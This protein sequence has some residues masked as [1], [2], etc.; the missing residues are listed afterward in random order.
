MAPPD[1]GTLSVPEGLPVLLRDLIHEYTGIFF[2]E[3]R[4]DIML[5]K[6]A[7]LA[8]ARGYRSYM[9]YYYLLKYEDRERV[10]LQKVIE[11]LSVLETYF[12]RE[13]GQI[14]AMVQAVV[15]Q[16]FARNQTPLRI[17]SA[18]CATGE[19]P[20]TIAIAL[21]EAGWGNHP[22]Q[23]MG[24]DASE[25]ALEKARRGVYRERAFR[26]LPLYLRQKYFSQEGNHFHLS[27]Q[28]KDRVRFQR[29]N[30]LDKKEIAGLVHAPVVFCRNVFIYFSADTIRRALYLFANDMPSGAWL[31]VGAS[32]S[33]LKLTDRFDLQE[34]HD[35][36]VYVRRE[37]KAI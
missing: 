23:I 34:L 14:L 30:I 3:P 31:F 16:W 5:E 35:A 13:M 33:L 22:I 26:A 4:F 37:K 7:D 25:L 32:E 20:Y 9:E 28:I 6:L 15:P 21:E 8:R 27:Q 11:A 19:E 36:F 12:W 1:V 29:A 18:A 10:E 17:W 2:D 24:S